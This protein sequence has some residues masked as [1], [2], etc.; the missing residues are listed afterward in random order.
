ML[1]RVIH[2]SVTCLLLP[3]WGCAGGSDDGSSFGTFGTSFTGQTTVTDDMDDMDDMDDETAGDGDGDTG[4]GDGDTGDGDGDTGDGDGDTGDGDTGDGDGEPGPNCGNGVIDPG[5]TCDGTNFGGVT[6][7]DL[8]YDQGTL[9]CISCAINTA[10]CSNSAQPGLGQL[11]S[12]CLDASGCPG[13]DG[14]AT[15]SMEGDPDPF[16]GFCTNFCSSDA[17][18]FANVGG[19][20]VP[21]CNNEP[22]RYCELDCAGGKTCPGGMV[23][24]SLVGGKQLCY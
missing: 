4:D 10:N 1:K 3:L 19:S 15:V 24:T 21:R 8:G 14:C 11:Y 9:T 22:D 5:E 2:L 18:C 13:L 6:C 16:D 20:A 23:C 17:E 12:H 7:V